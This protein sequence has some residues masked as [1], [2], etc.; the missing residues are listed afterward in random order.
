MSIWTK[1]AE[2]GEA[3][4]GGEKERKN[5]KKKK[6]EERKIYVSMKRKIYINNV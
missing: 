3:S 5:I 4:K 1:K 2:E 6:E